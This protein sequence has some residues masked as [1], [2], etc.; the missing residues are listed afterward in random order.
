MR[1][2]QK[3]KSSPVETAEI[4][5]SV[6]IKSEDKTDQ[7]TA[8]DKELKKELQK[9]KNLFQQLEDKIAKLN[10]KK[11][12]LE[13]A[14]SMPD[15][16]GNKTKFLETESAYS[17]ITEDLKKANSEYEIVFEKLMGL[18]DKA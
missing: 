6:N 8:V 12:E 1:N 17:T 9:Q 7:R 13:L 10:K 3:K 4:I 16:Y 15:V 14:L 2:E 18:E 5:P 11:T